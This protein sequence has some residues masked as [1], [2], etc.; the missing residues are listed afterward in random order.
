MLARV[1]PSRSTNSAATASASSSRSCLS[2]DELIERLRQREQVGAA[3]AS[4]RTVAAARGAVDPH[5]A[6][7]EL[8]RRR[9]VV[10]ERRA[11]RARVPRAARRVRAK[12]SSQC[13]CAGLYEP[14]SCATTTSSNG[15]P[16]CTCEAA[17]K[18]SSV[19]ERIASLQPRRA[20]LVE[21]AAH[22]GERAPDRAATRR[23]RARCRRGAPSRR[24]DSVRTS[25]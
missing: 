19:L 9:D 13:L 14:I 10:E 11:R 25:R 15:T 3:R 21:R 1:A 20:Q 17:M 2:W 5:A 7:A 16:I 18:S 23:A 22:L 8:V 6:Q 4:A 24:I 12:N